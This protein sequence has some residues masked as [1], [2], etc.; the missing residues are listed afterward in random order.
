MFAA[1][2]ADRRLV[3]AF[4]SFIRNDG[5]T[6]FE[7]ISPAQQFS[8]QDNETALVLCA[9]QHDMSKLVLD[10]HGM[11]ASLSLPDRQVLAKMLGSMASDSPTLSY[12]PLEVA[13]SIKECIEVQ[14]R[15][16]S[17]ELQ[18][19]MQSQAPHFLEFCIVSDCMRGFTVVGQAT[20]P[21]YHKFLLQLAD[22]TMQCSEGG[23]DLTQCDCEQSSP[24]SISNECLTS[25]VC[26][27]MS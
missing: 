20:M 23:P 15:H 8:F 27:S 6:A 10:V 17:V 21:L 13:A 9:Q 24:S 18:E 12:F 16:F 11:S 22:V 2:A 5:R 1:A 25:G 19:R 14:D 4:A 3:S 26:T 7:D